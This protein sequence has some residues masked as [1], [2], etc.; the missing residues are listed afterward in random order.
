MILN[1][2]NHFPHVFI[3]PSSCALLSLLPNYV[4]SEPRENGVPVPG[5]GKERG[6]AHGTDEGFFLGPDKSPTRKQNQK[7]N[8]FTPTWQTKNTAGNRLCW[9]DN[10]LLESGKVLVFSFGDFTVR[11]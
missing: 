11:N 7:R 9:P 6:W 2:H 4:I 8:K 1:Q 3:F 10:D 5:W